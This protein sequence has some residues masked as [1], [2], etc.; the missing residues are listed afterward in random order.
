[1]RIRMLLAVL[2]LL[3]VWAG[4][5]HRPALAAANKGILSLW[6]L[7][8]SKQ[9][10]AGIALDLSGDGLKDLVVGAPYASHRNRVGALIVYRSNVRGVRKAPVTVKEGDGNLGWS[11]AALGDIN[12]DGKEDFAAG[13]F[14]GSNDEVSLAGTVTVFHGNKG[15]PR[16]AAVLAGEMALDKFGYALA[17]GDLNGDG[18]LDLI[19]GAPFHCPSPALYQKGAVYVYF[20]PNYDP[21]GAVKIA[22]TSTM[23]GIGF[24]VAAGDINGDGVDDLLMQASGKVAAYYGS[25]G[26][27][28]PNPAGPDAVF[29]SADS[30]FGKAIAV[31]SDLNGDGFREVAIGA[32][33]AAINEVPE[34]GRLFILKGGTGA[35][36]VNADVS[37]PDLLAKIDGEANA[38]R[39]G[40]VLLPV[41]DMDGDGVPDLAVSAVHADG[42]PWLM[43][44]KIFLFS[45][46][47]LTAGA[48]VATSVAIS[49]DARDMH[50]GNFLAL[51]D[52]G[53]LLAA[54]APSE[55]A[56]TGTVRLFSLP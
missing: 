39:F 10:Q 14:S 37:S 35:R 9:G 17:A 44:G 6:Y 20:G 52:S 30:G 36:T 15:K 23:G 47:A 3:P 11:L 50:L 46:A 13:A 16:S 25:P 24:S 1:M 2:L 40:S 48:T 27:F 12:G 54:G 41:G 53:K 32:D 5:S 22:A 29:S 49:G 31:L 28:V 43:T 56:N 45:G 26:S 51:V 8:G 33:L 18:I 19:V 55:R 38:G 4:V 34:S 42:N 7:E 21:A